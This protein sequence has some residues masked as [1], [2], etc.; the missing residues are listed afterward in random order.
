MSHVAYRTLINGQRALDGLQLLDT[1][2]NHRLHI[3]NSLDGI[4]MPIGPRAT[5]S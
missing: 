4:P 2:P 5:P 3:G 1:L